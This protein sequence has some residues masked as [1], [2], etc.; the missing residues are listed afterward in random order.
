MLYKVLGVDF[1][2]VCFRSVYKKKGGEGADKPLLKPSR[3]SESTR[4]VL[5]VPAGIRDLAGLPSRPANRTND[6]VC[7]LFSFSFPWLIFFSETSSYPS[8]LPPPQKV[9]PPRPPLRLLVDTLASPVRMPFSPAYT[10]QQQKKTRTGVRQIHE[11][12]VDHETGAALPIV[13]VLLGRNLQTSGGG[14]CEF[15]ALCFCMHLR[16]LRAYHLPVR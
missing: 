4:P 8:P 1:G 15:F 14:V 5:A 6:V 7:F 16:P 11:G 2:V 13:Q 3:S 10:W 12:C 9:F